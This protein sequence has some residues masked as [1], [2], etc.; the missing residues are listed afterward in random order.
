MNN[1]LNVPKRDKIQKTH[2]KNQKVPIINFLKL[3]VKEAVLFVICRPKGKNG[4]LKIGRIAHSLITK[5]EVVVITDLT[6][7]S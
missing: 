3:N 1:L 2:N 6:T 7:M 4:F 5:G